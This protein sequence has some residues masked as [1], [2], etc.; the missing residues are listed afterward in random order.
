MDQNST[1][2]TE[3][4]AQDAFRD[5]SA[6]L[7]RFLLRRVNRPQDADDLAQEVFTRLI[8]VKNTDLV[9]DPQAYVIGIAANVLYE[10]RHRRAQDRVVFDSSVADDIAENQSA[11]TLPD[12]ERM[13]LRDSLNRALSSLPPTHRLVLLLVKRDGLSHR[14]AAQASGLSVHTIEKYLVEARARLR[15]LLA[16]EGE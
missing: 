14:E 5:H 16:D 8:R 3:R 4:L 1:H 7:Y 12:V 13:V 10:Y 6:A 15:V 9:R 2:L 11:P